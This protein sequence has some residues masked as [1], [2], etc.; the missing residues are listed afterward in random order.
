MSLVR[1]HVVKGAEG[2]SVR[3]VA[4]QERAHPQAHAG[5]VPAVKGRILAI[6]KGFEKV[7]DEGFFPH[8][9]S[10]R[11]EGDRPRLH[12]SAAHPAPQAAR[13]FLGEHVIDQF[14]D[15]LSGPNVL[16]GLEQSDQRLESR[17]VVAP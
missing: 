12:E 16:V 15:P 3:D 9:F 4:Q 7:C 2:F 10:V 1:A 8:P 13:V 14:I 11:S 5:K 6:L 17:Y